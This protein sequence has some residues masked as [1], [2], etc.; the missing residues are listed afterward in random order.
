MANEDWGKSVGGIVLRG[1][2]VLLVKHT[3]G[4]A[5]DKLLIPGGYCQ[6]GEMPEN[7]VARE[8]EEETS[9]ISSVKELVAIRFNTNAWYAIF[10]M[11][12]V[13]GNPTSDQNEN[14]EAVFMDIKE[15]I[16][17]PQ[18]TEITKIILNTLLERNG[19]SLKKFEEYTLRKGDNWSLYGMK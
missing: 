17:H 7:A 1:N 19:Q 8:V 4:S 9:I 13:S 5:K 10:L 11:D 12:Y 18:S 16:N 6:I 2:V 3:Y 15:A 14:S